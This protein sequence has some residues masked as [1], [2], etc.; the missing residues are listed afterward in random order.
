MQA[1]R[2]LE[3]ATRPNLSLVL[4]E[5]LEEGDII[6]VTDVTLPISMEITVHFTESIATAE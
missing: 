3:E 6:T 5:L 4:D 1:P 2:A